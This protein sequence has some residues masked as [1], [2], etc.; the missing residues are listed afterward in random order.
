M[1]KPGRS[2]RQDLPVAI[3]T[4]HPL[5]VHD[6]ADPRQAH[7]AHIR[8]GENPVGNARRGGK[9]QLV[10]IP[11]RGETG[12]RTL[13]LPAQPGFHGRGKRQSGQVE[14]KPDPA[15]LRD[16]PS[17]GHQAVGHIQQ[18]RGQA[19]QALVSAMR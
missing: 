7:P 4:D 16:M 13:I 17:I 5:P 8:Q 6:P 3:A 12:Q 11:A 1:R 14:L 19:P 15:G 18:G 10:I 9:E 2:D